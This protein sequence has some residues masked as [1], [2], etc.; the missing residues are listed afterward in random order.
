MHRFFINPTHICD[1]NVYITGEDVKHITKV[2]RLQAG[3]NITVSD[4]EG[5]DYL[6]ELQELTSTEVTGTILEEGANTAEPP[7]DVTMVQ[8]LPK[9]EKMEQIIQKC[10]EL[11]VNR[12]IPVAMERSVVQLDAKKA[13]ARRE[14]WQRVAVEAAKQCQRGRIPYIDELCSWKDLWATIA[15]DDLIIMPWEIEKNHGLQKALNGVKALEKRKIF[16]IIGPEG[17]I[18][19]GEAEDARGQGALAVS[20]GPRILR[21]E[22]AGPAVLAIIMY[23]LGDLGGLSG[24]Q[25]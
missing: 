10:T 13:G 21:T 17:G 2:L 24:D 5:R 22:T 8:G 12:I 25:Q 11:G 6:V 20:L 19:P 18:S 14:R 4:G 23:Q 7:I 9:G 16:I 1:K 15:Q 3:D